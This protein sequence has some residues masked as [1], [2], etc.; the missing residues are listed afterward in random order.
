M[1]GGKGVREVV[2]MKE[3]GELEVVEAFPPTPRL[4]LLQLLRCVFFN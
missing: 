2:G 1:I 3:V 4:L